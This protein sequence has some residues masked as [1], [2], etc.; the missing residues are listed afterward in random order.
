MILY[1]LWI[2]KFPFRIAQPKEKRFR[3]L[4]EHG[5]KAILPLSHQMMYPEAV[6]LLEGLLALHPPNRFTLQEVLGHS[7]FVSRYPASRST[8]LRKRLKQPISGVMEQLW[9]LRP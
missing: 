6:S 9:W 2:N 1:T 3:S 4:Q 5:V 8:V 7:F